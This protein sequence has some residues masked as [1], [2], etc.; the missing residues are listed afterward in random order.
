MGFPNFGV[1]QGDNTGYQKYMEKVRA[2][3]ASGQPSGLAQL[4]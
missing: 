3:R 2:D 4:Y 1:G